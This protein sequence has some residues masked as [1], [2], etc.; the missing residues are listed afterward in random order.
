[1][2]HYISP[3][4]F[5]KGM[6][7]KYKVHSFIHSKEM[8]GFQNLIISHM[9]PTMTVWASLSSVGSTVHVPTVENYEVPQL[10][11]LEEI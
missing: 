6:C 3:L 2:L 1:V 8:E 5:I 4:Y 10:C 11:P 9:T 7:L